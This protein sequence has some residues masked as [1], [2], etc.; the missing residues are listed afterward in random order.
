MA[1]DSEPDIV[2]TITVRIIS[3]KNFVFYISQTNGQRTFAL[4]QDSSPSSS[5]ETQ[6]AGLRNF[7][8]IPTPDELIPGDIFESIQLWYA[9]FDI[10]TKDWVVA[11]ALILPIST[12][13]DGKVPI[14]LKYEYD[15]KDK[16]KKFSG[17]LLRGDLPEESNILLPTYREYHGLPEKILAANDQASGGI[18]LALA[19]DFTRPKGLPTILS[20]ANISY[21]RKGTEGASELLVEV[22]LVGGEDDKETDPPGPPSPFTWDKAA[23]KFEKKGAENPI[24]NISSEFTLKSPGSTGEDGK[25]F[26][27]LRKS[28][29]ELNIVGKAESINF[30]ML[31]SFFEPQY[32]EAIVSIL[33]KI[34]IASLNVD[35]TYNSSG[36]ASD[37]LFSGD[38]NIGK[39]KLDF[40]YQ[41]ASSIPDGVAAAGSK[42]RRDDLLTARRTRPASRG[43]PA[44]TG[45]PAPPLLEVPKNKDTDWQ[46]DASLSAA[47]EGE[48]LGTIIE[49]I[50]GDNPLPSFISNIDVPTTGEDVTNGKPLISL[51]VA[52]M[53]DN[54]VFVF[55]VALAFL[56]FSFIQISN[57]KGTNGSVVPPLRI[58]RFSI[59]SLP[60]IQDIPIV[61]ELPQPYQLLTYCYVGGPVG[62][63]GVTKAQINTLNSVYIPNAKIFYKAVTQGQEYVLR[64]GHHFIVINN[65]ECILDHVFGAKPAPPRAAGGG[66]AGAITAGNTRNANASLTD[67]KNLPAED[68]QSSPTKGTLQKKS[69][70]LTITGISVQYKNETLWLFI[71]AT[72]AMGPVELSLIGFG[73]GLKLGGANLKLNDLVNTFNMTDLDFQINGIAMNFDQ[74]PI[75]IAGVFIHEVTESINSYRGG[76]AVGFKPYEFVAVGEYAEVTDPVTKEKYK[77]I[78]LYAK[79]DGPLIDLQIAIIK[80]VRL[81]FGY[82]SFVRSPQVHEL[83]DFPFISDSGISEAGNNPMKIL[84]GMRGGVY[85]WVAPKQDSFWFAVGFS[86]SAF[87][88]LTA[89]A[90]ALVGF[91]DEGVVINI[92]ADVVCMMPPEAPSRDMCIVYVELLMNAELNFIHDYFFVQAALAPTSFL[93]VPQCHLYGGFAMGT[94]FGRSD[95]AGD[96]VFTVGGYHRN[97]VRPAHYPRPD[98]LGIR[99]NIGDNISIRGEG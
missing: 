75:L 32:S 56:E 62:S 55:N 17:G 84:E 93:L 2:A 35:Y 6:V 19:Y 60:F 42:K 64:L 14:Y 16:K 31:G 36:K 22:E 66:S 46:F 59:G 11:L 24:W 61:K 86:V 78:F 96:W 82:N 73:I 63:K 18:D 48:N 54:V 51:K 68:T 21:E 71:D 25:L 87:N 20:K 39:L 30:A 90:V 41:Y 88:L 97:F 70:F 67:T 9:D 94:W 83:A 65:D 12:L 1:A 47:E 7:V 52:K 72:L 43:I 13:D 37:F 92:L 95:Y 80:G 5:T 10:E 74:P 8:S 23:F 50:C 69:K 89:T 28:G 81:G 85:P 33:G 79:L 15:K 29:T 53:D 38:I 45:P 91:S 4:R 98:R 26:L 76:I 58:L 44:R 34:K 49:S 99:F 40:F 3:L 57:K 27:E 77:S